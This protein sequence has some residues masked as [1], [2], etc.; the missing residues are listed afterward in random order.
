MLGIHD[1]LL[2]KIREVRNRLA[3]LDKDS[4]PESC[5]L[6][7]KAISDASTLLPAGIH[8]AKMSEVKKICGFHKTKTAQIAK[9]LEDQGFIVKLNADFDR[10]AKY[11]AFTQKGQAA[12]ENEVNVVHGIAEEVLGKL[13]DKETLHFISLL[14]TLSEALAVKA[15]N[16]K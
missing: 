8:A 16:K 9:K 6:F 13:G 5:Y 14:D 11:V 7:L 2:Y 15:R 10:R 3:A 12:L 1:Q 4:L